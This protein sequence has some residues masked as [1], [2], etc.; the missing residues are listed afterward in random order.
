[1]ARARG[2]YELGRVRAALVWIVPLVLVVGV[3]IV[4]GAPSIVAILA[5]GP[6]VAGA[7]AALWYGGHVGQGV[8]IG[9]LA[10][11][12][13]FALPFAVAVG[14]YCPALSCVGLC[15]T[16]SF[17]GGIAGSAVLA[18]RRAF[19][20]VPRPAVGS[21]LALVALAGL[22]GAFVVD[23]SGLAAAGL[24]LALTPALLALPD[25]P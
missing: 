1:M 9:I 15:V 5:G 13:V 6:L 16:T 19:E 22:I 18:V 20:H 8:R 4:L 11:P 25:A 14:G 23:P 17:V 2:A 21:A 3:S 7:G 10:T 12:G 24:A